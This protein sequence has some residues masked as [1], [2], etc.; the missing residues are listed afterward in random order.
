[1]KNKLVVLLMLGFAAAAA[2]SSYIGQGW[3]ARAMEAGPFVTEINAAAIPLNHDD[4]GLK[5]VGELTY[6][7]GWVLTAEN[8][9]F[10]GFS[11]MLVAPDAR[12]LIALSDKGDWL[13]ASL[14]LDQKTPLT[15]G[16]L[17]PFEEGAHAKE[18]GTYDAE[19]LVRTQTGFLVGLEQ[20]HRILEVEAVGGKN[21]L[22]PYNGTVDLS[23]LSGNGGLE[24]MTLLPNGKLLM[25]AEHGLDQ[26][27]TLPVWISDKK[28]ATVR[29]FQPPKNYSPTDAASLPNGDVLLL[30]RHFSTFDGVSAKVMH[31]S[32]SEIASQNVIKGRELAHLAPPYAVDN[33]EALDIQ[34][35]ENGKVRLFMM[36]DDNFNIAQETLLLVFDWQP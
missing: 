22:A 36:S 33:M 21:Q 10:G 30:M 27:G 20:H 16:L 23:V 6:V 4:P 1:M 24:A 14:N 29:R 11:S 3:A 2:I 34:P 13:T 28:T 15:K 8:K 31:I 17:Y 32:A 9:N 26:K 12:S 7:S 18:D 19:S 5:T 25:F 35:L